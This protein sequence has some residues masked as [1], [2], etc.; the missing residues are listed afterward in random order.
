MSGAAGLSAA[1]RRRAGGGDY[2]NTSNGN[3]GQTKKN[4]QSV[5]F[6]PSMN[7]PNQVLAVHDRIIYENI[8]ITNTHTNQINDMTKTFE[9]I[10]ANEK[11]LHNRLRNVESMLNM[12]IQKEKLREENNTKEMYESEEGNPVS[13]NNRKNQVSDTIPTFDDDDDNKDVENTVSE[14]SSSKTSFKTPRAPKQSKKTSDKTGEKKTGI[15]LSVD[16][17]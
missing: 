4:T 3:S 2:S 15:T 7:N 17:M 11:N 10:G 8:N 1:K 5:N 6:G 9:K 12:L 16:D 13:V 14:H